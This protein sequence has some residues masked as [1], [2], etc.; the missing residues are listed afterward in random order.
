MRPPERFVGDISR[1]H[2]RHAADV[3]AP[4]VESS[5]RVTNPLRDDLKNL[6]GRRRDLERGLRVR[7]KRSNPVIKSVWHASA[8]QTGDRELGIGS[9]IVEGFQDSHHNRGEG[10]S[11]RFFNRVVEPSFGHFSRRDDPATES[12]KRVM[13]VRLRAAAAHR[14]DR[15][16]AEESRIRM[17]KLHG[18]NFLRSGSPNESD[19]LCRMTNR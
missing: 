6:L 13:I 7:T 2:D 17:P 10:V 3:D 1:R 12:A 15:D 9:L 14:V 5:C 16:R 8:R 11:A 19:S 18:L 4:F